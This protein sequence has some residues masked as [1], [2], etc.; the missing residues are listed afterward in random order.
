MHLLVE[1]LGVIFDYSNSWKVKDKGKR[2]LLN[3]DEIGYILCYLGDHVVL[4]NVR[5]G[6]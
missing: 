5:Q 6:I 3:F 2:G 4:W 1:M